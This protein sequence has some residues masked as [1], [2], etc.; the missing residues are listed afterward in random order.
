M[1][2]F[3]SSYPFSRYS[4]STVFSQSSPSGDSP[5]EGLEE[6]VHVFVRLRCQSPRRRAPS[7][8]PGD[9]F[10]GPGSSAAVMPSN[11]P[12]HLLIHHEVVALQVALVLAVLLLTILPALGIN[13]AFRTPRTGPNPAAPSGTHTLRTL[14]A[15]RS[16]ART[17]APGVYTPRLTLS[18]YTR[19]TRS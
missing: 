6:L 11:F 8:N 16:R 3:S 18:L 4:P 15:V 2:L 5:H 14:A 9:G 17:C 10:Q 12:F 19:G 1:S 13:A 7:P